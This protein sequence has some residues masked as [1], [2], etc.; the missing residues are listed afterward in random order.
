MT[1]ME[2]ALLPYGNPSSLCLS[3]SLDVCV[4]VCS[5]CVCVR[6][7]V[8]FVV[9]SSP[10]RFRAAILHLDWDRKQQ[11]ILKTW[12]VCHIPSN[13]YPYFYVIGYIHTVCT[14]CT[15]I[16]T[17]GTYFGAASRAFGVRPWLL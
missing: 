12:M 14:V 3:V 11:N 5:A 6:A 2:H 8:T 13:N 16:T 7:R 1:R 15:Y 17:V 10:K 4:Y 9:L